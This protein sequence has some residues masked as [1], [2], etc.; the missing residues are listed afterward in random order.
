MQWPQSI[1]WQ[2]VK[3]LDFWGFKFLAGR[4]RNLITSRPDSL[5][6]FLMR[7]IL[8]GCLGTPRF[9]SIII[10]VGHVVFFHYVISFWLYFNFCFIVMVNINGN[11]TWTN[12]VI[13]YLKCFLLFVM[14][15]FDFNWRQT[16]TAMYIRN[17]VNELGH[18]ATLTTILLWYNSAICIYFNVNRKLT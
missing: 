8:A 12:I 4:T 1:Y 13:M 10:I 7:P 2:G 17:N 11:G 14:N 6:G 9:R 18:R 16:V 5:P 3:P 15:F